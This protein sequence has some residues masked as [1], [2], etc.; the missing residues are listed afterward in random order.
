MSEEKLQKVW[1]EIIRYVSHGQKEISI[2]EIAE[3]I[4]LTKNE[5]KYH[6]DK[7]IR[8]GAVTLK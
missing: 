3:D 1:D 5:V 8:V 2:S 6:L 4:G 7:L